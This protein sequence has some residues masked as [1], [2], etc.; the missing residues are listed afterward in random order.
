[1][2]NEEE[3]III[4]SIKE[5]PKGLTIEN[6]TEI[7][8]NEINGI[9][10]DSFVHRYSDQQPVKIN[11]LNGNVTFKNLYVAGLFGGVN[12]TRLNEET[13]KLSG[14]Q[15]ISST[16]NFLDEVEVTG[17][18]KIKELL[19][20]IAPDRYVYKTGDRNLPFVN[21]LEDVKVDMLIVEG[22]FKGKISN[23]NIDGFD[24]RRLSLSK[25]QRITEKYFLKNLQVERLN[26]SK[27]N[28]FNYRDL[29][30][31]R[32]YHQL[33]LN[34][35]LDNKIAIKGKLYRRIVSYELAILYL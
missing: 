20:D 18:F 2:Q 3:E 12:I 7:D 26:A 35:I 33:L 21:S 30:D 22:D 16:L 24:E 28:N 31:S 34:R 23:F 10:I 19:N 1:M 27:I 15:F 29:T 13:V 32:R 8:F 4:T 25:E 6:D 17:D 9:S 11:I 5:F 14:E